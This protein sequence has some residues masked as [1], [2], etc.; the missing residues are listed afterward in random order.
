MYTKYAGFVHKRIC[1][2]SLQVIITRYNNI[3]EAKAEILETA[4]ELRM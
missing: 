4:L 1:G 3:Q 2:V